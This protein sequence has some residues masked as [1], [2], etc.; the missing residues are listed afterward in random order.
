MTL[1]RKKSKKSR[2][3]YPLLNCFLLG[4]LLLAVIVSLGQ[5]N[6][7]VY[8]S[9]EINELKEDFRILQIE[10][11]LLLQEEASIKSIENLNEI[12]QELNMIEVASINYLRPSADTLARLSW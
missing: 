1:F 10:N 9:L 2:F 5:V 8:A 7:G 3:N 11:E 6:A 4:T 12:S